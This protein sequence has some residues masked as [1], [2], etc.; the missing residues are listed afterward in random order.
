[1]IF[2]NDGVLWRVGEQAKGDSLEKTA[3]DEIVVVLVAVAVRLWRRASERVEQLLDAR[4]SSF[5]KDIGG[6]VLKAAADI[7]LVKRKA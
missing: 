6:R 3:E 1:V 4:E 7:G 2:R 5:L